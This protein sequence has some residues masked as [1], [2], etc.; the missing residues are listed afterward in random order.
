MSSNTARTVDLSDA[1]AIC[2]GTIPLDIRTRQALV[3]Y[4]RPK[5][6]ILFPKGHKDI[7]ESLEAA[8]LRE[9]EEETGYNCTLLPH[10]Q[11]THAT[12]ILA[13]T[14]TEPVAVQ[15]R[16][17]NNVRKIIFWYLAI[18][19]CSCNS[20]NQKLGEGEDFEPRWV[21]V[22]DLISTLTFDDDKQIAKQALKAAELEF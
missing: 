8:A 2:C 10:N 17:N 12:N 3:L 16:V 9:T 5:G 14:H 1:F 19:D 7:G 15:Q 13:S 22:E 20:K 11:N 21:A 4:F 18:A 6:E